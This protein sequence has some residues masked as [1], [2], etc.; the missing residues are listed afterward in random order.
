ME[1]AMRGI[2]KL[3]EEVQTMREDVAAL[4]RTR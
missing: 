4:E 2:S 1:V 3:L